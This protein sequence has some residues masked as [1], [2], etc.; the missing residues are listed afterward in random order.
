M[1][2]S[3]R[4]QWAVLLLA[5]VFSFSLTSCL[6]DDDSISDNDRATALSNMAGTY[7]GVLVYPV[8]STRDGRYLADSVQVTWTASA[9]GVVQVTG[10]P[11]S[12]FVQLVSD[13]SLRSA[14]A[15]QHP[16]TVNA[17]LGVTSVDGG[18]YQFLVYP[19]AITFEGVNF[20]GASHDIEMQ[21]VASTLSYGTWRSGQ[22][23]LQMLISGIASASADYSN[24]FAVTP[25]PIVLK[26]SR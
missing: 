26:G 25:V 24:A 10:V 23:S 6:D 1:N 7:H 18:S 3:K 16:R 19:Q 5:A 17:A 8:N 4:F 20:G 14:L 12:V 21:F 2:N 15:S 11:S 13:S 9:Q 22:M